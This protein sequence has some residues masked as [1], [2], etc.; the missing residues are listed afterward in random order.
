MINYLLN[1]DF[2]FENANKLF[3]EKQYDESLKIFQKLL[4]NEPDNY[5]IFSK[6]ALIYQIKKNYNKAI[7]F[8]KQSLSINPDNPSANNNLGN[9]YRALGEYDKAIECF[10]KDLNS[11]E[12]LF[13]LG[14]L[15]EKL[16]KNKQARQCF[17]NAI[18]LD[19]KKSFSIQTRMAF[20][21]PV[22]YES[23][24]EILK[25]RKK[26]TDF[27]T[28]HLNSNDIIENPIRDIGTTTFYLGY[29]GLCNKDI[30]SEIYKFYKNH[31]NKNF[32]SEYKKQ[33]K[34]NN[35]IKIGFL[36]AF[37]RKHSVA[38]VSNGWIAKLDK[39]SFETIIFSIGEYNDADTNFLKK[40]CNKFYSLPSNFQ[41][42]KE[43]IL[44]ELLDILFFTD[45]GLEPYTY[46][47]SFS[48]LA[49][50]Q[51]TYTGHPDTTGVETIDYYISSRLWETNN[52]TTHYSEKLIR[53]DSLTW[54][55]KKP[56][57]K[58]SQLKTRED[59]GFSHKDNIYCINQS[60]FKIH[61]DFD[62][63]LDKILKKDKHGK[64]AVFFNIKHFWWKDLLLKR[65]KNSIKNI[66]RIKFIPQVEFSY[67]LNFI[68]VS[69]VILDTLYFNGGTTSLQT[70]GIGT[71]IVTMPT[72]LM[73]GRF[74]YGM[75]KKMG[76]DSLI[77]TN[78]EDY[79]NT[80]VTVAND[81]EFNNNLRRKIL[82]EN[83]ILFEDNSVVNEF[84]KFF[85]NII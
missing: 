14:I 15:F 39:K 3:F 2:T 83:H 11:Y 63:I 56:V 16:G 53:F 62:Y 20:T 68:K 13:N 42:I 18:K 8:Y 59:F 32:F 29:H 49:P 26:I 30:N 46:F 22:I 12:N 77:T 66:D 75:Y 71:P 36:S 76:I 52:A 9:I 4:E 28:R 50:I 1:M 37:F 5:L 27:I 70:F 60:L 58:L 44:S 24:E 17:Y 7:E 64:I 43:T 78:A 35:K 33:N 65:F 41:L 85:K 80:A 54:Y 19:H 55:Y 23:K 51:L 47:L 31:L 82:L 38:D 57:I 81:K 48:K 61:P 40:H 25:T 34:K 67:Y 84:E 69:D 73:R 72:E 6:I 10:K 45:I 74:T 21:M 79:I